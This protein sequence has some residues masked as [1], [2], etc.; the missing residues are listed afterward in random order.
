MKNKIIL[1]TV[2][3]L[4]LTSCGQRYDSERSKNRDE[5]ID[6]LPV[7]TEINPVGNDNLYTLY[8]YDIKEVTDPVIN[9]QVGIVYE[10]DD[11]HDYFT[12][13]TPA[14]SVS[15]G[16]ASVALNSGENVYGDSSSNFYDPSS[17]GQLKTTAGWA[18]PVKNN[19]TFT[20]PFGWRKDS[21]GTFHSGTDVSG[22]H[23][24]Y[25]IGSGVVVENRFS[26]SFGNLIAIQYPVDQ[27][28][29]DTTESD[30]KT[31]NTQILL[32]NLGYVLYTDGDYSIER[33]SKGIDMGAALYLACLLTDQRLNEND[34]N[35]LANAGTITNANVFNGGAFATTTSYKDYLSEMDTYLEELNIDIHKKN[36][37]FTLQ[38][39]P[40][41]PLKVRSD[42]VDVYEH[43]YEQVSSDS[44]IFAGIGKTNKKDI[45]DYILTAG[46]VSTSAVIVNTAYTHLS[47]S[48]KSSFTPDNATGTGTSL[49]YQYKESEGEGY[50]YVLYAHMKNKSTVNGA[51]TADT[52]L[53][54][55]GTTGDSTG[56]HLHMNTYFSDS[57][58]YSTSKMYKSTEKGGE[59]VDPLR[60][61]FKVASTSDG[62]AR[63]GI[64]MSFTLG[65]WSSKGRI[66]ETKWRWNNENSMTYY[67][68]NKIGNFTDG[69]LI[70]ATSADWNDRVTE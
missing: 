8:P 70:D 53:G 6:A 55:S 4:L 47:S 24:L 15:A 25:A 5:F 38:D 40:T 32:T 35:V 22:V 66:G 58:V 26:S 31:M 49:L 63:Y 18:F 21:S 68:W 56:N 29:L 27:T 43:F 16:S 67:T 10:Y 45:V 37:E 52:L 48:I 57:N 7:L 2:M 14:S 62:S 3:S 20:S 36:D 61:V 65:S 44:S 41:L 13:G 51:V 50:L 69:S 46:S 11:I 23:N 34:L 60:H 59:T 1:I 64:K 12:T 28:V 54:I 17:T 42:L 9:S 30:N 19:L 39:L 33:F